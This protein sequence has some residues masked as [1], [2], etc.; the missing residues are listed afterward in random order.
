MIDTTAK[1]AIDENGFIKGISVVP[2]EFPLPCPHFINNTNF[3][4]MR[5]TN[6]DK[7]MDESSWE[8]FDE[9]L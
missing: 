1:I 2:N 5:C 8:V 7:Y 3:T 6:I 9:Q 4:K